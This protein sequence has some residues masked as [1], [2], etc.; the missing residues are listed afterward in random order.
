M[1]EFGDSEFE[2]GVGR[3]GLWTII[4]L[5]DLTRSWEAGRVGLDGGRLEGRRGAQWCLMLST[6]TGKVSVVETLASLYC[7]N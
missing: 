4:C 3:E 6:E 1:F 5:K 2:G 7:G